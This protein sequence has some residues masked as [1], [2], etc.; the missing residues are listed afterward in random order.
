MTLHVQGTAPSFGPGERC[1]CWR[2]L[3][4]AR[5]GLPGQGLAHGCPC[6]EMCGAWEIC[7][8]C[9]AGTTARERPRFFPSR[10]RISKLLIDR[11][12]RGMVVMGGWG[13]DGAPRTMRCWT[14]LGALVAGGK[15][16]TGLRT[17]WA[18]SCV[19]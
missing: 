2:A 7:Q 5:T 14:Q 4:E 16:E 10:C 19:A 18:V 15:P 3:P 17:L 9:A 8:L 1:L 11:L 6:L 12:A 13:A